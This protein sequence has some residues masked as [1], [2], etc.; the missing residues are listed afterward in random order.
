MGEEEEEEEEE[1]Y[2]EIRPQDDCRFSCGKGRM[3]ERGLSERANVITRSF[4]S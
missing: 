3:E 4:M 2:N 1:E